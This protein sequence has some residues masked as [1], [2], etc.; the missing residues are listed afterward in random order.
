MSSRAARIWERIMENVYISKISSY[1]GTP[2][3]LWMGATS[4]KGRGGGYGRIAIDGHSSAVHR[5]TYTMV[6]GY[7]ARKRQIDHLCQNRSCCNPDHL[8]D[9]T[10]KQ[11]QKRRRKK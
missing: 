8:E 2:C 4:G 1:N 10:H 3:W 5:V 6:H 11:N 9:V 7:I